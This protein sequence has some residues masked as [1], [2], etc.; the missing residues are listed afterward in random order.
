MQNVFVD[1]TRRRGIPIFEILSNYAGLP[2]KEDIIGWYH[3]LSENT[4]DKKARM[5]MIIYEVIFTSRILT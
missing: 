5:I 4:K 2:S 3:T 1:A